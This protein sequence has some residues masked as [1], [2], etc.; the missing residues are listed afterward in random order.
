M[1]AFRIVLSFPAWEPV[2]NVA[3]LALEGPP[4]AIKARQSAAY[5][6]GTFLLPEA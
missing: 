2:L 6:S 3:G 4:P 1:I 5:L